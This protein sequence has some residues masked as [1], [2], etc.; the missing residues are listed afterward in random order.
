MLNNISWQNYWITVSMLSAGYYLLVFLLY[1]RKD[2]TLTLNIKKAASNYNYT[3]NPSLAPVDNP[4]SE[5]EEVVAYACM[6]E[7]KAF[8]D[9]SKRQKPHKKELMAAVQGIIKKYPTLK[10]SDY[11]ETITHAIV[12]MSEDNCS[13]H[14]GADDVG[15]FW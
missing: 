12:A 2:F 15:C 7:L 13:V 11:K 9:E 6:D 5:K 14:L 1:F 3:S 10:T 4:Y 8:F